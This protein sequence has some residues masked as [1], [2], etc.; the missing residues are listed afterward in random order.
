MTSE[1][2]Y[3]SSSSNSVSSSPGAT[4]RAMAC[5]STVI[6]TPGD[7]SSTTCLVPTETRVPNRPLPSITRVP[8]CSSFMV[9]WMACCRFFCGRMI[10]K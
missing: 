8:G 6:S 2:S 10:R 1:S 9:F 7:T 4:V 3:S 5:L